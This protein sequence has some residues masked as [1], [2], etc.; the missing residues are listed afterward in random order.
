MLNIKLA[1]LQETGNNHVPVALFFSFIFICE[2]FFLFRVDFDLLHNDDQSTNFFLLDM[3]QVS[4]PNFTFD[5]ALFFYSNIKS[6]SV[7]LF[8]NFL[9]PFLLCGLILLLAMVSAIVLT[10]KKHFIS[11]NQNVYNQ[12]L[13]DHN[14]A[15][16]FFA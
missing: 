8:D 14:K 1:E 5:N 10:L 12:I 6:I 15:L 13:K 4:I 11:K 7:A 16:V 3:L 2:L 9:Y